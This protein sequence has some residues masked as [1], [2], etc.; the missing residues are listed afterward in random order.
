[1]PTMA[2][3][4]LCGF[5]FMGR[6]HA[7]VLTRLRGVTLAG[8]VDPRGEAI[9]PDLRDR[10]GEVPVFTTTEAALAAA[11]CDVVDICLP[12]DL[13]RRTAELAL[14]AGKHVFCEK[15][16]ALTMA[17]AESMVQ[18]AR[19]ANRQLMVGH[20]LRFWPEYEVLA[21]LVR[22][23][24]H[25][26]LVSLSLSRRN[27]RPD[28]AVGD[29]VNDPQR[30]IGAALDMHIHDTDFVCHLLGTPRGVTARGVREATGWNSIASTYD[31]GASGPL[32]FADGAWNYPP[33]W[34]FHMRF[35]AVFER[36]AL[37][38]D[39][40]ADPTL[41]LTAGAEPPC[42]VPRP[43]PGT[44]GYHGELAYFFA[45]LRDGLPVEIST[46]EQAAQSLRVTLAEIESAAHGGRMV[47]FTQT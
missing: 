32:V 45:R 37:D 16:L 5:G 31:Y 46:G 11:P 14:S 27:A 40:R 10:C 22:S 36:A 25:G 15:P 26:A 33:G 30:C 17:D 18:A 21:E 4:L 47:S 35:S 12:T 41:L 6:V 34:G 42:P 29:W 28:Y 39:S 19:Q 24:E 43:H 7:G 9:L 2:R 13:H 23:G 44:D 38:F 1:M 20:C 8:V 3:V